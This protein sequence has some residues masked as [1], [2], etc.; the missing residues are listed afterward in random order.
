MPR[1]DGPGAARAIRSLEAADESRA[2][3]LIVAVTANSSEED[4]RDCI[5]AGMNSVMVKPITPAAMRAAL[6][7]LLEA[8][9]D[10]R[11]L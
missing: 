9:K 2:P 7:P 10:T 3:V 11:E 5:T 8:A 4:R 6:A 1:L